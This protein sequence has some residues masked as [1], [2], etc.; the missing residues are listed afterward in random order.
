MSGLQLKL[1]TNLIF[2][3]SVY[4]E[5]HRSLPF[6]L[7]AKPVDSIILK[8]SNSI[9]LFPLSRWKLNNYFSTIQPLQF[10]KSLIVDLQLSEVSCSHARWRRSQHVS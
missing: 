6:S 2:K 1:L 4:F 9:I 3:E 8:R 7:L 10:A 5:R